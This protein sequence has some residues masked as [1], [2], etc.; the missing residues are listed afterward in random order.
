[1]KYPVM[2]EIHLSEGAEIRLVVSKSTAH[3][4]ASYG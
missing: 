3:N 4:Q 1:M 2:S